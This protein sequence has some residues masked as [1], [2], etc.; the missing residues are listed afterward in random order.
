MLLGNFRKARGPVVGG[1]QPPAN[2]CGQRPRCRCGLHARSVRNSVIGHDARTTRPVLQQLA[3][4]TVSAVEAWYTKYIGCW[5]CNGQ[6]SVFE[7]DDAISIAR[8]KVQVM[9]GGQDQRRQRAG[10]LARSFTV[11]RQPRRS[12]YPSNTQSATLI[13]VTTAKSCGTKPI[14][15]GP[16]HA[17][18][19]LRVPPCATTPASV[20][21]GVDLPAPFGPMT[22]ISPVEGR[23]KASIRSR[24][25]R[26]ALTVKS[27]RIR[28]IFSLSSK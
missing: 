6:I 28:L 24:R 8:R 3:G 4:D 25:R 5:P 19:R 15:S 9:Q 1:I 27:F 23:G 22:T 26:P 12:R 20:L 11:T 21:S 16:G 14:Q 18:P 13:A 10:N 2:T 7:K 17:R